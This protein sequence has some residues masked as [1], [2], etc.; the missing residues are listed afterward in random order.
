MSKEKIIPIS[1]RG[2]VARGFGSI[3]GVEMAEVKKSQAPIPEYVLGYE[4]QVAKVRKPHYNAVM[5]YDACIKNWVFRQIARAIVQEVIVPE[6]MLV[7][8]FAHRCESC[9]TDFDFEEKECGTCGGTE[10]RKPDMDERKKAQALMD[11]PNPDYSL[12]ELQR[13]ALNWHIMLDDT[14]LSIAY[15][16]TLKKQDGKFK[17]TRIPTY[18]YV[19]DTRFLF[20]VA[21]KYGKF[22]NNEYFCSNCSTAERDVF[23]V[24]E[25]G[26]PIP[27]KCQEPDCGGPL[28]QTYYVQQI[29]DKIK[30]RFGEN[31]IKQ[32]NTDSLRPELFG[33]PKVISVFKQL[34]SIN[35]VDD[36]YEEIYE[37]GNTGAIIA[38]PGLTQEDLD[39][40]RRKI[41]A[42]VNEL[43]RRDVTTG[44]REKSKKIRTVMMAVK[45]D[46]PISI[47]IMPN[48]R[49]MQSLEFYKLYRDSMCAVF[50][51]TPIFVSVIESGKSG[52][53][54]RM[55]IDVQKGTTEE[56]QQ[57]LS[58]LWNKKIFPVFDIFDWEIQFGSIEMVDELREAEIWERKANATNTLMNLG[59]EVTFDEHNNIEVSHEP[60]K[61]I[62]P[63]PE[64][65]QE[66]RADDVSEDS[67]DWFPK[68]GKDAFVRSA[69]KIRIELEDQLIL[70][71]D[72]AREV[73]DVKTSYAQGK[74]VM[75]K[76]HLEIIESARLAL[77][78][79]LEV[80][81]PE[82]P[83]HILKKLNEIKNERL[84]DFRKL[85]KEELKREE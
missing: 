55:Q 68:I 20:P 42:E 5:L 1:L 33:N 69:K 47:A 73:N 72:H 81:L 22:G 19:E 39:E 26:K 66:P 21:D 6:I 8:K 40:Q 3:L 10:F 36:V 78:S 65:P 7:K 59:F 41:K 75:D 44:K 23:V 52:N 16:D 9:G 38:F 54:P 4:S 58:D 74:V 63:S 37:E 24:A 85:L 32:G 76:Y 18:V 49:D 51:V 31:E 14:Y 64:E 77:S 50:G 15:K 82:V 25:E 60:T 46:A 67:G 71:V 83:D 30:H 48:P 79:T 2:K 80:E 62:A 13:S 43:N 84:R 56:N 29:G 35:H 12:K 27:T 45:G 57:F 11:K 53:N 28:L 61:E 17:P 34:R 70:I